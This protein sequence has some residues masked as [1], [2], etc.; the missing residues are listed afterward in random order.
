M[1]NE[2]GEIITTS[3]D[4]GNAPLVDFRFADNTSGQAWV[5]G[6][7]DNEGLALLRPIAAPRTYP[8]LSFSSDEPQRGDSMGL[9]QFIE[10]STAPDLQ[11]TNI[12]G[13]QE[14]FGGCLWLHINASDIGTGNGAV[15]F[16]AGGKIQ[17]IRMPSEF[18]TSAGIG[19]PGQVSACAASYLGTSV[20]LLQTGRAIINVTREVGDQATLPVLPTIYHGSLTVNGQAAPAGT[21]V[22]ARFQKA[23]A[24]DF[25]KSL[26]TNEAGKYTFALAVNQSGYDNASIEFWTNA[27]KSSTT[28]VYRTGA[29]R[30]PT[31]ELDLAF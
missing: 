23:G 11:N 1:F 30:P 4:L 17:G 29:A 18:L 15:V 14:T 12:A 2:Q 6:R 16:T 3:Q 25:W 5:H 27:Q 24:R 8:F 7:N 26:T 13:L 20:P 21:T 22:Y 10:T 31:R 9:I 28:D 19:R